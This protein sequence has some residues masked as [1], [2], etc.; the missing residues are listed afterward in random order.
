KNVPKKASF[1]KRDLD[2]R[3]QSEAYRLMF[4]LPASEKLDGSIDCTLLTPYNKK[5]VAGRLF[6][7]QNYVC[8]DSRIKAQVSVV[9][10]L[11]DV[12]SAEKIETNVSNQALDKAIIVTTRDVLNKTNF[13]FAQI[14]DRDFV[15]EKLSELLAKT[16]EMTTFSGS[17]RSKG[18][19]VDLEPEWKPQQ[20]LMNI[21]PLSP[22]PEVN[23]RQQQRAREWEEH[24]NTYGRGVWM[25]R[26][27]EV[28]KLVLEGIPDH[29]RMQ[30]WMSFS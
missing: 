29:L 19:L 21:F 20:A 4:R 28:A 5:F 15:V 27:T 7:S 14:L 10:P 13:I 11:R 9:I 12:V 6:L 8:F 25:Y 23:K 16:Q 26:T 2:A 24:F 17:N 18:S 1:L 22:I 30:I 3:A